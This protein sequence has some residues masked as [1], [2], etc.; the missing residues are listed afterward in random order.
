MKNKFTLIMALATATLFVACGGSGD[1]NTASAPVNSQDPM[2]TAMSSE[3]VIDIGLSSSEQFETTP[4]STSQGSEDLVDYR[5]GNTYRTVT[6]GPMTWMAENLRYETNGSFCPGEK[7]EY[8]SRYGCY[9]THSAAVSSCPVGWHLSTKAEWETL[10][11]IAGGDSANRKL[12]STGDEWERYDASRIP[13][14]VEGPGSDDFGFSGMPAG[15]W[16]ASSHAGQG[17]G[18]DFWAAENYD[19]EKFYVFMLTAHAPDTD[20]YD[21]GTN[22]Y[23]AKQKDDFSISVRCVKN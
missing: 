12:K 23:Y 1:T 10:I 4:S 15:R 21:R 2:E 22:R 20:L 11:A 3:T 13:A 19:D 14:E 7:Y 16:D 9:Y 6:I 5:D 8:D 17:L 18:A